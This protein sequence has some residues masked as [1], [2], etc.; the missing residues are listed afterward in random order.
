MCGRGVG[1]ASRGCREGR[2]GTRCPEDFKRGSVGR[3][4]RG[5]ANRITEGLEAGWALGWRVGPAPCR[6]GCLC[7]SKCRE[8]CLGWRVGVPMET[9]A[10][11][12]WPQTTCLVP[13]G[14]WHPHRGARP[15]RQ[16]LSS[17]LVRSVR[18]LRTA[19]P[20]S[21]RVLGSQPS[22]PRPWLSWIPVAWFHP[23]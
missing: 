9:A 19:T 2:Q 16:S 21:C 13:L 10:S 12:L 8:R 20:V 4:E 15:R 14:P 23:A 11:H 1:R 22:R 5:G 7:L 6:T 17:C 3:E 18:D